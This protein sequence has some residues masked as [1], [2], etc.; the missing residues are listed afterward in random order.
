MEGVIGCC[1][2]RCR[3]LI[4]SFPEIPGGVRRGAGE[5]Q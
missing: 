5:G 3:W 2:H 1:R 4:V